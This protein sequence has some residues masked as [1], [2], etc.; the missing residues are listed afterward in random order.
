[1][2]QPDAPTGNPYATP[3][4]RL[5]RKRIG[6]SEIVLATRG[7]RLLAY[8]L[9]MILL[10]LAM[11]IGAMIVVI[12]MVTTSQDPQT[13]FN[14][15]IEQLN[16]TSSPFLKINLL[17][18]W[19]YLNVLAPVILYFLINGYMLQTRGQTIGK[20][21]MSIGIVDKNTHQVPPLSTIFLRRYL[22]FNTTAIIN[23]LLYLFIYWSDVLSIFRED[24]RML[25][26]LVANTIV[27]KV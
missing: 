2:N 4:A 5:T 13:V 23:L 21:L 20:L 15:L 19:V 14:L 6:P 26:D 10:Y 22:P 16:Q 18:R 7:E 25:H 24:K 8:L 12:V 9:D 1:M 27:I 3:L 11:F 17:D